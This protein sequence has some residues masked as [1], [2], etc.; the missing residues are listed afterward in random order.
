MR[1]WMH[2]LRSVCTGHLCRFARWT[3]R[4]AVPAPV[5]VIRFQKENRQQH[6]K[7]LDHAVRIGF[8]LELEVVHEQLRDR[9]FVCGAQWD[10]TKTQLS[11]YLDCRMFQSTRADSMI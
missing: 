3:H 6:R 2:L 1:T 8:V 10:E 5:N 7:I 4:E 9:V 11:G